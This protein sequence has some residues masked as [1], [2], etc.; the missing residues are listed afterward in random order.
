[1]NRFCLQIVLNALIAIIMVVSGFYLILQLLM[2]ILSM[3]I[4][5]ILKLSGR[6]AYDYLQ[7]GSFWKG[8]NRNNYW[9]MKGPGM[10]RLRKKLLS[11]AKAE[12]KEMLLVS[13]GAVYGQCSNCI[14]YLNCEKKYYIRCCDCKYFGKCPLFPQKGNQAICNHFSCSRW[15]EKD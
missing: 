5:R 3:N 13:N 6:S 10:T 9:F 11:L 15:I 1:M 14:F 2:L 4:K 8:K 7:K 12:T